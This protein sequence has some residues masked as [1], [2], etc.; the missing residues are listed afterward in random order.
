MRVSL[1][2]EFFSIKINKSTAK[3]KSCHWK[4]GQKEQKAYTW[5]FM[6][7]QITNPRYQG[8]PV[9]NQSVKL[10]NWMPMM[11]QAQKNHVAMEL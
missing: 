8:L 9:E 6:S 2:L 10:Y 1:T 7:T 4:V 3:T 5:H 11:H